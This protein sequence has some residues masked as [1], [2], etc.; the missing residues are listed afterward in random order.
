MK[1]YLALAVMFCA[2]GMDAQ[3]V[4]I[5]FE[6][7]GNG[8]P[9]VEYLYDPQNVRQSPLQEGAN[10]ITPH[11]SVKF[12]NNDWIP[13]Y[14]LT[15][16]PNPAGELKDILVDGITNT[17]Y[18]Y[19]YETT[20]SFVILLEEK[21]DWDLSIKFVYD[22][23]EE[24]VYTHNI[25][26]NISGDGT[27][28][29]E[30]T[31]AEG[32]PVSIN[33]NAGGN[34]LNVMQESDGSYHMRITPQPAE[35]LACT[36]LVADDYEEYALL[37]EYEEQGYADL[38][39]Y[40]SRV[41][42]NL[43]VRFEEPEEYDIAVDYSVYGSGSTD[44]SY[45]SEAT[46][47]EVT[48]YFALGENVFD[49][50]AFDSNYSLRVTPRPAEDY[51]VTA[52]NLG[53]VADEEAL[54][55][56]EANGYFTLTSTTGR[57]DFELEMVYEHDGPIEVVKHTVILKANGEMVWE[58]RHS[59]VQ[60]GRQDVYRVGQEDVVVELPDGAFCTWNYTYD[61]NYVVRGLLIDGVMLE[62]YY[63][64]VDRDMEISLD[65][66]RNEQYSVTMEK[67]TV[68]GEAYLQYQSFN[69]EIGDYEWLTLEEGQTV[70][71]GT[72]IRASIYA[73]VDYAISEI[74]VNGEP[75]VTFTREDDV[76][77]YNYETE[78]YDD[79]AIEI[80]FY[81]LVSVDEVSAD[82]VEMQVYAID[83]RLLT[84]RMASDVKEATQGLPA[85]IYIVNGIKVAVGE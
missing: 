45:V 38:V 79:L 14:Q 51:L 28:L 41:T 12:I 16:F 46:G 23:A 2:M 85:G 78:V 69:Q 84:T 21:R 47:E 35:G 15:F 50:I 82:P 56:Y 76:Y 73:F 74:R 57:E 36:Y 40:D 58:L 55:E 61:Y 11:W 27:V 25:Y 44:Y 60:E 70:S 77:T 19:D 64:T 81:N 33:L 10:T 7:E 31:D 65:Y 29:C 4:T 1:I 43:D 39:Y 30:Y 22:D 59:N 63:I 24:E 80:E 54:A 52:I 18:M 68:E 37:E 83:G 42:K 13:C 53:G 26:G 34:M 5:N 67:P 20:G 32:N 72:R 75:V 17:Q 3:T 6:Q 66:V 48:G 9:V 49:D 71:A 8:S 62:D